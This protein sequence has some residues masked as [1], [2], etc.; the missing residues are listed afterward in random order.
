M[1]DYNLGHDE[2][3]FIHLFEPRLMKI[4]ISEAG[5]E[6]IFRLQLWQPEMK[7]LTLNL[8]NNFIQLVFYNTRCTCILE[9]GNKITENFFIHDYIEIIPPF[10]RERRYC[11]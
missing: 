9:F 10:F 2:K 5:R 4:P 11:R 3:N 6:S 1:S 8:R 7:S